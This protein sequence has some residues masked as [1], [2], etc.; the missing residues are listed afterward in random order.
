MDE[1]GTGGWAMPVAQG[2]EGEP[3]VD[4]PYMNNGDAADVLE[5]QDEPLSKQ[6]RYPYVQYYGQGTDIIHG[7]NLDPSFYNVR[8]CRRCA[9][10]AL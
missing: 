9:C 8:S 7:Q 3:F 6:A 1:V 4:Y 5:T 2:Y 10:F